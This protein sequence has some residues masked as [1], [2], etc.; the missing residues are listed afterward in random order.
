MKIAKKSKRLLVAISSGSLLVVSVILLT[1][2]GHRAD[3]ASIADAD[4]VSAAIGRAIPGASGSLISAGT[5]FDGGGMTLAVD[6]PSAVATPVVANP[7][8]VASTAWRAR[9]VAAD[10]AT[11]DPNVSGY[12]VR[13]SGISAASV[14]SSVLGDLT[15]TLPPRADVTVL[16]KVGSTTEAAARKQLDSNIGVL[17]SGMPGKLAKLAVSVKP[18]ELVGA[19]HVAFEVDV[20]ADDISALRPYLGDIFF[21]LQTGLVGNEDALIDGVGVK[22]SEG[23][24]VVA[25]IWTSTRGLSGETMVAPGFEMPEAL[26]ISLPFRSLIGGPPAMDSATG[27]GKTGLAANG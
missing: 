16:K 13:S 14:P 2:N 11:D 12:Q 20:E 7:F 22:L 9:L 8:A 3:A 15:G 18:I 4:Q 26:H 25:A 5:G 19:G 1:S 21:G 10:L 24:R 6:V 23:P 27:S 17:Q